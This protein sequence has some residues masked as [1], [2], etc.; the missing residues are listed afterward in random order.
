MRRP[1]LE[2]CISRWEAASS[3]VELRSPH[4]LPGCLQSGPQ[5]LPLDRLGTLLALPEQDGHA[6]DADLFADQALRAEDAGLLASA[7]AAPARL[8]LPQSQRPRDA[9]N[10]LGSPPPLRRLVL[11]VRER[12]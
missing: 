5:P 7:Q 9:R 10:P 8:V 11:P 2:I 1:G 12:E 6:L 4:G 3:P